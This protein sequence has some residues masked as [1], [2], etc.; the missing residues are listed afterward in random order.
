MELVYP[1]Q[2]PQMN[3]TN[4]DDTVVDI[5]VPVSAGSVVCGFDSETTIKT[6]IAVR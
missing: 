4:Y 6:I 5:V 2:H 3:S 1:T